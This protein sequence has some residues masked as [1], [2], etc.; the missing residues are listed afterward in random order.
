VI[1]CCGE[2][3]ID[4]L[5]RETE[6]RERA[7]APHVGG[8]VFNTA[9]A[10]G[11]LGLPT[12]FFSGISTDM[13][14]AMLEHAL[15]DSGVDLSLVRFSDRP[16]TLAFVGLQGGDARYVFYDENS[17]GRMVEPTDLPD[18]PA[19]VEALHF[20]C[21]S[22]VAEPCGSAYEALAARE[23]PRRVIMLDPNLRPSFIPD[24]AR[25]EARLRRMIAI[26]DIVKLSEEDLGWFGEEGSL[27]EIAARW[28]AAGPKLMVVTR[29]G[30]GATAWCAAGSVSVEARRVEVADTVGAGDTFNAGIL[31]SLAEQGLLRKDRLAALA[32]DQVA[33][34]LDFAARASAV[35]VSRPGA[36]PPW[37]RELETAE[38]N[39]E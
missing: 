17:A 39:M 30:K 19:S 37:R 25:H 14:G 1:L 15:R 36:D 26:A 11:R 32:R 9:I 35:T 3:L 4:M 28:L 7:F 24:K 29:G 22:L 16:T 10:L 12:A 13:F 34:V 27:D 8:A 23:A 20:S 6:A 5:P 31:A 33:A 38:A 21:I 2:A 18:I